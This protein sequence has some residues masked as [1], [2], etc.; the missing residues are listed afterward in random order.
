MKFGQKLL[1]ILT[2]VTAA[3]AQP[4]VYEGGVVNAA[5][6]S[7]VG[8]PNSGIAQG[9]MFVAFGSNLG[10]DNG[11]DILSWPLSTEME[12][13]SVQITSQ[14][15]TVD[16]IM[17]Y[18]YPSQV[19]GILPSSTPVGAAQ[20]RVTVNGQPSAPVDI[21]V[22]PTSFGIF[23]W[24]QAGS[25]P[26]IIQNY[27][28][29]FNQPVNSVV[30]TAQTGQLGIIWGTGLVAVAGDEAAGPLP[31]DMRA[32]V[33]VEVYVGG[34]QAQVDYAG[35]SGCCAGIDQI[36]FKVPDGLEGCYVGVVVKA[37]GVVSNFTSMSIAPDEA[38]CSD[39]NGVSAADLQQAA[40]GGDTRLGRV[41]LNHIA[42]SL[43]G[44]TVASD[45]ADAVFGVYSPF[46]MAAAR[47]LTQAPSPG[48]CTVIQF[49]GLDPLVADPTQ[50]VP[51]DAGASLTVNGPKGDKQVPRT[52]PGLYNA[53]LGGVDLSNILGGGLPPAGYFDPGTYTVTNGAGAAVG[54]INAQV[55]MPAPVT[56]SNMSQIATINRGQD[57]DI[58]W[59]G[60]DPNTFVTITGIGSI[61]GPAGPTKDTPA[62]V[63]LCAERAAA[64]HFVVPSYVLQALPP[65]ANAVIPSSFLLVGNS[66][67]PVRFNATG[68]DV[69]Y[70]TYL[71]VAGKNVTLQ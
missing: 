61:G 45:S 32:T 5:S 38:V 31:G 15:T 11:P 56:W 7:I 27:V 25:G 39:P 68:L 17:L 24:N 6:Y 43:L 35:R 50:P 41:S 37:G 66:G 44:I 14:G 58:Q 20:L 19:A 48:S 71:S 9:S 34:K 1:L 10:V 30:Q 18:T 22:V 23:A 69:G 26:G 64:G 60:G 29:P 57:L 8:L 13:T 51:L 63:F 21:T 4:V 49:K 3:W 53:V 54:A 62:A 16:A 59:T 12:G 42:L 52:S 40:A 65:S 47:G 55:T 70:L 28:D 33:P 46:Q 2:C 36:V 67:A